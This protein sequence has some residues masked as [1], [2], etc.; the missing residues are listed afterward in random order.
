MIGVNGCHHRCYIV[1]T[2]MENTYIFG[3]TYKVSL[4]AQMS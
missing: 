2:A 3:H 1:S 4:L